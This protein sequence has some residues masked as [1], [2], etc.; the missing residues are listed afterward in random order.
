MAYYPAPAAGTPATPGY[1]YASLPDTPGYYQQ[2]PYD[3]KAGHQQQYYAPPGPQTYGPPGS[4]ATVIIVESDGFV[5]PAVV[6][7]AW[8][9]YHHE[10]DDGDAVCAVTT[11]W[12]FGIF[13]ILPNLLA[14]LCFS[15]HPSR[16]VQRIVRGCWISL[17]VQLII[18]IIIGL[19][20]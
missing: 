6:R 14:I 11:L 3:P 9:R 1:T 17:L 12:I 7:G 2:P 20:V 16:K 8:R 5:R 15:Y 19:S 13:F 18:G 10:T 4:A